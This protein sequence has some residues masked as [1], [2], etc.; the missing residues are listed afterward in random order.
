MFLGVFTH[1]WGGGEAKTP[2]DIGFYNFKPIFD[3]LSEFTGQNECFH[4]LQRQKN[5]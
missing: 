1:I 4:R 5:L 2:Y 3:L